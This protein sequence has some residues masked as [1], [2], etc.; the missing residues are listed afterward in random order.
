MKSSALVVLTMLVACSSSSDPTPTPSP[1]SDASTD[2][3]TTPVVDAGVEASTSSTEAC[4]GKTYTGSCHGDQATPTPTSACNDYY[5]WDVNSAK[6]TC[7]PSSGVFDTTPCD[8]AKNVG[9]CEKLIAQ[10]KVCVVYWY[11]DPYTSDT[12]QQGCPAPAKYHAP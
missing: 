10:D 9:S 5:G 12:V 6:L 11:F 3:A 2:A 1:T 8:K 4:A 7:Q